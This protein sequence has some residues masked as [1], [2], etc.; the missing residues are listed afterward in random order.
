MVGDT[1]KYSVAAVRRS[2][3]VSEHT[4]LNRMVIFDYEGIAAWQKRKSHDLL[5]LGFPEVEILV[6]RDRRSQ[7]TLI[8]EKQIKKPC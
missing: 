3:M 4:V 5:L 2:L 8:I 1:L 7:H 6:L